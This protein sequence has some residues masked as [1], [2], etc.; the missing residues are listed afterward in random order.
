M[1]IGAWIMKIA[2]LAAVLGGLAAGLYS[3]ALSWP[4]IALYVVGFGM[5]TGGIVLGARAARTDQVFAGSGEDETGS[6]E[7]E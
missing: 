5:F 3:G 4:E 7:G 1:R 6:A 2:G